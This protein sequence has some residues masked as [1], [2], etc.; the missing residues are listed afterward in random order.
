MDLLIVI[1]G[2][3][4]SAI[5]GWLVVRAV[6]GR[7]PVLTRLER[8]VWAGALGTTFHM[9]VT[10]FIHNGGIA[11]LTLIGFLFP[12]TVSAVLIGAGF[13]LK[14]WKTSKPASHM[15]A[16]RGRL[17]K[18]LMMLMIVLITWSGVKVLAGTYD[19]FLTPTYW[20]DSFNNWN[21]R[22]KIFYELKAFSLTIPQGNNAESSSGGVSS[23]PPSVPMMKT[24][25]ATLRGS[26]DEGT[27]NGV[28][29]VWFWL[30]I[31]AFFL[32][33]RR[34]SGLF[35]SVM[36]TYMLIS[37]PMVLIH[38]SNPYAEIFI[39]LHILL[40]MTALFF[41]AKAADAAHMTCWLRLSALAA[42]LMIFTKN[43]ASLLY[44]PL[45][46]IGVAWVLYAKYRSRKIDRKSMN[47]MIALIVIIFAVFAL[48]WL[49]YKW[50]YGLSFGNA[51][52]VT[53]FMI[54]FHP[55]ALKSIWQQLSHEPT[56]LLL[57]L[58]L[59][60]TLIIAGKKAWRLPLG[61]LT[62]FAIVA[63]LEQIG[64]YTLTTNLANEAINQTGFSRG[65]VHIAPIMV[66]LIWMVWRDRMR[67][68][69]NYH[70]H[71]TTIF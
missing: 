40:A 29:A 63:L 71:A 28:H 15:T 37:L 43:E 12:V 66:C 30:L 62:L 17:S 53:S 27:V 9:L 18:P 69:E 51:K 47:R 16:P 32:M 42:G 8:L 1:L 19:L 57:P 2:S 7:T 41:S 23:Y 38:G 64:I 48:P 33:L 44:V 61:P 26:W 49:T 50:M 67:E 31:A 3:V 35:G 11:P 24:W 54:K 13:I 5:P 36:G 39:A 4:L 10:F 68:M 65:M 20:D 21:L 59:P 60:V 52:Y 34:L 14:F 55:L 45:W 22:G 70:P 25:L 46:A 56:F 6:E 58:L